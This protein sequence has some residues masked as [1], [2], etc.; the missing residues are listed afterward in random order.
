MESIKKFVAKGLLIS[1]LQL[2][3]CAGADPASTAGDT[4]VESEPIFTLPDPSASLTR[5]RGE[6]RL[7]F[8]GVGQCSGALLNNGIII[9]AAHCLPVPNR[10]ALV[11][12]DVFY[13]L[14]PD[15]NA[16]FCLPEECPTERTWRLRNEGGHDR[17]V[18]FY[19][20]PNQ[21]ESNR[22]KISTWWD[23]AVGGI[24]AAGADCDTLFSNFIQSFGL[25][26]TNFLTLSRR[27]VKGNNALTMQG[28]GAPD[29]L[30]HRMGITIDSSSTH[31]AD[32]HA[33]VL[34]NYFC[35]GDSGA[36]SV[37][38]SGYFDSRGL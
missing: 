29:Q 2:A 26:N 22:D 38:S 35:Q 15:P 20:H 33:T 4:E 5:E 34:N 11:D 14:P 30:H 18:F 27:A 31:A 36:P 6:V 3:G 25:D 7:F 37:R 1:T 13:E 19:P 9:T 24:C 8:P 10:N 12:V 17:R 16:G 23:V 32:M 28:Y 21:T